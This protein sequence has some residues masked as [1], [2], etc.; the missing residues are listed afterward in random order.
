VFNVCAAALFGLQDAL[1]RVD[2][3]AHTP[4]PS[5]VPLLLSV[6][7]LVA[8]GVAAAVSGAA[9]AGWQANAYFVAAAVM[10]ATAGLG[11]LGLSRGVGVQPQQRGPRLR[12]ADGEVATATA[13]DAD[14]EPEHAPAHVRT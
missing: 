9:G 8:N 14:G 3:A 7:T 2:L 5:R 13:L 4:E 1:G 11:A 10:Q 12:S 6:N